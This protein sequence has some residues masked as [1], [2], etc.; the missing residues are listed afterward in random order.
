MLCGDYLETENAIQIQHKQTLP[1]AKGSYLQGI[2]CS[3]RD[4][5]RAHGA[6]NALF[7]TNI[8]EMIATL[9]RVPNS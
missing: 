1:N 9:E 4:Q 6:R 8:H 2:E 5:M 7:I 3:G